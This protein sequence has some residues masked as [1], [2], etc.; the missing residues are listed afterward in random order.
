M[1]WFPGGGWRQH[2]LQEVFWTAGGQAGR[3]SPV[4]YGPEIPF[5]LRREATGGEWYS[6]MRGLERRRMVRRWEK[7]RREGLNFVIFYC[8]K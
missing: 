1:Q 8:K 7:I 2:L 6:Q 3:F 5:R 4:D